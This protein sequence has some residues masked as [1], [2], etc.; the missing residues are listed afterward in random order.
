MIKQNKITKNIN[1]Y[2]IKILFDTEQINN[3]LLGG[4]SINGIE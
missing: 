1:E 2:G 3:I 4:N